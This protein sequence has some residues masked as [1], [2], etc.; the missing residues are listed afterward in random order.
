VWVLGS[1]ADNHIFSM[2]H[3]QLDEF[4]SIIKVENPDLL[5]Y[6]VGK[7]GEVVPPHLLAS[8]IYQ[9]LCTYVHKEDKLWRSKLQRNKG[10]NQ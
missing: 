3:A 7:E 1:W 8:G 2:T 10:G 6:L 5:N 4:E 9:S